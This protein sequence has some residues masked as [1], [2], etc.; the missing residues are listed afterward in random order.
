VYKGCVS[1]D[2]LALRAEVTNFDCDTKTGDKGRF[3]IVEIFKAYIAGSKGLYVIGQ[4]QAV[5]VFFAQFKRK[6]GMIFR[7]F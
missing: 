1:V 5:C 3:D 2:D 6:F 4:N 7:F